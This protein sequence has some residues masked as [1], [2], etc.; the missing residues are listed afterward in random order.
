MNSIQADRVMKAVVDG[1]EEYAQLTQRSGVDPVELAA[2]SEVIDRAIQLMRGFY[3]Y[4]HE[5]MKPA[6]LPAPRNPYFNANAAIDAQP[7][8]YYAYEAVQRGGVNR[9]RCLLICGQFGSEPD[10][11]EQALDNV[12]MP[13]REAN[14]WRTYVREDSD[15][16]YVLQDKPPVKLKRHLDRF[17]QLL[18]NA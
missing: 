3:K 7:P 1:V 6:G 10:V 9:E 13:W 17:L 8:E 12:I 16:R 11:A 14:H 5:N 2:Q 4:G 15:G 18:I